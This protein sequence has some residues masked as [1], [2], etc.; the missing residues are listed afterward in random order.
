MQ[1]GEI[2]YSLIAFLHFSHLSG[3]VSLPAQVVDVE[4]DLAVSVGVGD[5]LA[6]GQALR[7]AV[8]GRR[9]SGSGVVRAERVVVDVADVV[10]ADGRA[11]TAAGGV[12]PR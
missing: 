10:V 4:A 7:C 6:V 11:G 2:P 3:L 1:S 5:L 9:M 12:V 8:G